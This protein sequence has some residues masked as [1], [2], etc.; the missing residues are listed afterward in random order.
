MSD[1]QVHMKCIITGDKTKIYKNNPETANK[2]QNVK[3]DQKCHGKVD[4]RLMSR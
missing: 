1:Y 3:Q 4:P 2:V